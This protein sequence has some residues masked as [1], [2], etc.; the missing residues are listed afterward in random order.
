MQL[1]GKKMT[2]L[3]SIPKSNVIQFPTPMRREEV[4]LLECE[5]EISIINEKVKSL[6]IDLDHASKYLQELLDEHEVLKD[7]VD[8]NKDILFFEDDWDD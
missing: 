5:K 2:K 6:A 8:N 4:E 7:A 3:K 1:I